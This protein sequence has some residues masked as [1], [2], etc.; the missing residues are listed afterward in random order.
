MRMEKMFLKLGFSFTL[1]VLFGVLS[2]VS[3]YGSNTRLPSINI[4]KG[5]TYAYSKP[6]YVTG[7]GEL[8][9]TVRVAVKGFFGSGGSSRYRVAL[10][11]E[12]SEVDVKY[13]T[14]STSG[15]N[16]YLRYPISSCSRTGKYQIRIRNYSSQNPQPG[17]ASFRP[18]N[19]PIKQIINYTMPG[20]AVP[21]GHRVTRDIYNHREP[22]GTGRLEITGNWSS[23]CYLS[24]TKCKLIFRL[25]SNNQTVAYKSGYPI[26]SLYPSNQ[27]MRIIYNVPANRVGSD[28]KLEVIGSSIG[29]ASNVTPKLYFIPDCR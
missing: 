2:S 12:K 21:Q 13:V 24:P 16:V 5:S 28:W 25:K 11:R 1:F 19:R 14:T 6:F 4:K 7:K 22:K 27:R 15:K 17:A 8:K 29:S 10:M 18:F 26:T 3:I 23:D 20:F 9:I